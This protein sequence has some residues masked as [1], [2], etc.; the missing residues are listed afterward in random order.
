MD[1]DEEHMNG[2]NLMKAFMRE[3]AEHFRSNPDKLKKLF[4]KAKEF[5]AV[6][7]ELEND[8]ITLFHN[9]IYENEF[10]AT[11]LGEEKNNDP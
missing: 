9:T 11:I 10:M 5:M 6:F 2:V 1:R 3:K 4:D 8:F 7:P